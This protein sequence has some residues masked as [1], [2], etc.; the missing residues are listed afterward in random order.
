MCKY[1]GCQKAGQDSLSLCMVMNTLGNEKSEMMG[2]EVTETA[3]HVD[4]GPV[5]HIGDKTIVEGDVKASTIYNI[6]LYLK[7]TCNLQSILSK[8]TI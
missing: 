2:L 1:E 7:G 6:K 3:L 5:V 8:G 4:V